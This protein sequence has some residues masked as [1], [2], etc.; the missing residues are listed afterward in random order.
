MRHEKTTTVLTHTHSKNLGSQTHEYYLISGL[1]TIYAYGDGV[2]YWRASEKAYYPCE[3]V[4]GQVISMELQR[5]EVI[6]KIWKTIFRI[7]RV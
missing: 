1:G 6:E 5:R 3:F 4:S 2:E 7:I